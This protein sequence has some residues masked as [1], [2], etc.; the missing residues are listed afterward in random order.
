MHA[1]TCPHWG[2][3]LSGRRGAPGEVSLLVVYE[4]VISLL[5]LPT[6]ERDGCL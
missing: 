6:P 2:P 4:L 3:N 5:S 1:R